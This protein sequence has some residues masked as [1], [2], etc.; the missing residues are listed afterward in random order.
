MEY[1]KPSFICFIDLLKTFD[2][3]KLNDISYLLYNLGISNLVKAIE[4]IYEANKTQR[5]IEEK[6]T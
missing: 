6:L 3:V 4:N 2:S 1:N 5:K